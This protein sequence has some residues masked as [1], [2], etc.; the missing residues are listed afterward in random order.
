L[1]SPILIRLSLF[2][3]F[4]HGQKKTGTE[5]SVAGFTIRS[6][7]PVVTM[8]GCQFIAST[9]EGHSSSLLGIFP[10]VPT[11]M[12]LVLPRVI[13]FASQSKAHTVVEWNSCCRG[14][15]FAIFDCHRMAL[16]TVRAKWRE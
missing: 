2:V 11:A 7:S 13:C 12:Q 6:L 1:H 15:T 9:T 4:V 14:V 8:L 16:I 5:I 3:H 10:A